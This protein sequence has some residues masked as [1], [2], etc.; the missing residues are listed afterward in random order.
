MLLAL[1][2]DT[3]TTTGY[4]GV[5]SSLHFH[6]RNQLRVVTFRRTSH[7]DVRQFEATLE[8]VKYPH[9]HTNTGVEVPDDAMDLSSFVSTNVFP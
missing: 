5:E 2:V 3:G 7:L 9:P 4:G 6:R 8:T 1:E